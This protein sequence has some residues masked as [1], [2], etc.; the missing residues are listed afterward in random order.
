MRH[1]NSPS[2]S[3]RSNTKTLWEYNSE[4]DCSLV[5]GEKNNE[6]LYRDVLEVRNLT[7]SRWPD[8]TSPVDDYSDLFCLYYNGIP[9]GSVGATRAING[10][11]FMEEFCPP[12]LMDQYRDF[13][14]SAYRFRLIQKFRRS[15]PYAK[16]MT[17]S[18][19]TVKEGW[20]EQLRKGAGIDVINIEASYVP[21]YKR[22]GYLLYEGS[23]YIDPVLGTPSCIM[24]LPVDPTRSSIIQD[25]ITEEHSIVL[26]DDVLNTI[27]RRSFAVNF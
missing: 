14:V 6:D 24:F 18:F 10:P 3:N 1:L 21:L 23:E 9:I 15:S 5:I 19:I 13:I 22:L 2:R 20:R 25:I 7:D 17:L 4:F 16:G 27:T 8:Q 26:A 12:S 11:I